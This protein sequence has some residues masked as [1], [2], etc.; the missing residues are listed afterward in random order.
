MRQHVRRDLGEID[1]EVALGERGQLARRVGRPV[2]AIEIGE[3]DALRADGKREC[4]FRAGELRHDVGDGAFGLRRGF[5]TSRP[6]TPHRLRIDVVAQPQEYRRAQVIVVRPALI[7]HLGHCRG[8]DP[9]GRRI[10]LRRIRKGTG[11][12][13][14]GREL[15]RHLCERALIE[16]RA[17]VRRIAQRLLVPVTDQQRAERSA[18]ALAFRVAADDE[19]GGRGR[20]DLEPRRRATA[21]LVTAFLALADHALEAARER[22]GAERDPVIG[23]VHELDVRGWQQALGEIATPIAIA[24]I[25]QIDTGEVQQIEAVEDDRRRRIGGRDLAFRLE[26]RSFLQ[27]AERRLAVGVERDELA[28]EDH[29][30]H[31]LLSQL[32]R[33]LRKLGREL[34]ARAASAA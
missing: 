15:A 24:R 30:V 20:L 17:H 13:L 28:V 31:R 11:G 33:Q 21:G 1:E 23:N 19:I 3:P 2:D 14:Q 25:A 4:G 6:G 29:A 7:A 26:L 16:P 10:E 34:E 22:R 18:R 12:A 27:R 32:R 8:I 9:R 5:R